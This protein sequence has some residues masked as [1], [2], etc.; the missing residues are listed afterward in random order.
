M[1]EQ[2]RK[3]IDEKVASGT[4]N[5][6]SFYGAF[7][8]GPN[9]HGT[10]HVSVIDPSGLAVSV[11]STINLHLGAG[12]ASERTGIVLNNEMD[13]FSF[14]HGVSSYGLPP[15]P[16][17]FIAPGKRPLSSMAPMIFVDSTTGRVRLAIGAAGGIR[18]T[19]G[20]AYVTFFTRFFFL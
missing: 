3:K 9:D 18:I 20:A 14:P 5:D 1:A 4:S 6:P 13:D 10:S 2:T 8:H 16:A 12:F 17:N 19:S 11:T 15:C 7:T